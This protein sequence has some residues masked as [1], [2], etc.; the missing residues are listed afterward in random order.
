M[1]EIEVTELTQVGGGKWDWSD[2]S[3][4]LGYNIGSAAGWYYNNILI[5]NPW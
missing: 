2:I 4:S 5:G 1:E 3:G